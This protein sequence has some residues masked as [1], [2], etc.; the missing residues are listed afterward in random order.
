M[1]SIYLVELIAKEEFIDLLVSCSV[2]NKFKKHRF[3]NSSK[4]VVS[5]ISCTA[6]WPKWVRMD[7]I[8]TLL[9]EELTELWGKV[10]GT[11][12]QKKKLMIAYKFT[13]LLIIS[14]CTE[15]DLPCPGTGLGIGNSLS[16]VTWKQMCA[17]IFIRQKISVWSS[18]SWLRVEVRLACNLINFLKNICYM[19]QNCLYSQI[20]YVRNQHSYS[21]RQA[22]KGCLVFEKK[23]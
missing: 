12:Q 8:T 3:H 10:W 9:L 18:L 15:A 7:K 1:V 21:T 14:L 16:K 2:F 17:H 6:E 23:T 20:K 5:Q 11:K 22:T 4:I 19:K 13:E